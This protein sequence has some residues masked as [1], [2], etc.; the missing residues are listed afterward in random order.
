MLEDVNL[1][2][3]FSLLADGLTLH[4]FS[5]TNMEH[6]TWNDHLTPNSLTQFL[7]VLFKMHNLLRV[8]ERKNFIEI[9]NSSLYC[10]VK[11]VNVKKVQFRSS[12][13]FIDKTCHLTQLYT[14]SHFC[15]PHSLQMPGNSWI[16]YSLRRNSLCAI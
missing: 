4:I 8:L 15:F 1:F 11:L 13:W 5:N 16:M 10:P 6:G 3:G 9:L 7:S 2:T 12:I 14:G